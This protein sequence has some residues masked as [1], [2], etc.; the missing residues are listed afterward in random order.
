MSPEHFLARHGLPPTVDDLR[1]VHD[2]MRD[3]MRAGLA[4]A[5]S[6]L[7]MLPAYV[8]PCPEPPP[9]EAIAL[10]AGGTNVRAAVVRFD[11]DGE[12]EILAAERAGLPGG[13]GRE[14]DRRTFFAGLAELVARLQRKDVPLGFVFSYPTRILPDRDGVLL[15]WTKEVRA[16]GVVGSRV[17]RDLANALHARHGLRPSSVTVLNDTVAALAAG[18]T[19][20]SG[21]G[22]G[23]GL[24][25]GTGTNMAYFEDREAITKLPADAAG[26]AVQQA[27]NM[28]SGN[29]DGAPRCRFDEA[30]D[31]VSGDPGHQLLEKQVSGRYLG[32]LARRVLRGAVGKGLLSSRLGHALAAPWCLESAHLA[33]VMTLPRPRFAGPLV[34]A[35]DD[36]RLVV[37][38]LVEAVVQRSARLVAAGLAAVVDDLGL[39]AAPVSIVAEGTLFWSMPGYRNWVEQT[40]D[41]LIPPLGGAPRFVLLH[42]EEANLIGAAVAALS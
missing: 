34:A 6:C 20:L 17:G 29:F 24:I 36:D 30:L 9:G 23:I 11:E 7:R 27:I 3:A 26:D 42:I 2:R 32:E 28:E 22:G 31:A 12:A 38:R 18:S 21:T 40:L 39:A 35:A 25:V 8:P 19:V 1:P 4:G 15:R 5:R 10:D 37:H 33:D 16:E 41:D 14:V 13:D